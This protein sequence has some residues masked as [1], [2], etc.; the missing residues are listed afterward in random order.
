MFNRIAILGVG[1]LGASFALALKKNG[2]CGSITG[3]GRN[4]ENLLKAKERNIIDSFEQDPAAASRDADLI[5]LSTP[6]GS[7]LDLTKLIAPALKKGAVLTDVGSVKGRL[8]REIEKII[9]EHANYIGG[10]PIAGSDRSGIDA[11]NPGLFRNAKCIITPTEHSNADALEKIEGLW[12][13][14][15]SDILILN[16]EEHDRIYA[17]VSH[18]P[19]LVAYAMVNTVADMDRSYLDFSGKG[20][21]DATRIA[22]SSEELW[23]DICLLN[24]DNLVEVIAVFQKNLDM[25]TRY[26]KDGDADSLKHAFRKART[27][28]ETLG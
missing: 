15:G 11:A 12:K 27:L 5:M 28:R 25:L 21:M 26:L 13:A 16:P 17:S 8:V 7:F 3:Y 1:L 10:H 19:H 23:N 22:S 6:V 4:R 24:R 2:L 18:L 14:L 9:P 20:F